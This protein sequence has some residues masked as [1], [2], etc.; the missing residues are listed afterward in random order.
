MRKRVWGTQ[1]NLISVL[2]SSGASAEPKQSEEV[3][4]RCII[5]VVAIKLAALV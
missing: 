5:H 3:T 4:A 1:V 2:T